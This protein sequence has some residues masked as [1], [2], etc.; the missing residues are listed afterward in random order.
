MRLKKYVESDTYEIPM[1]KRE[2]HKKINPKTNREKTFTH[3]RYLKTGISPKDRTLK[4]LPRYADGKPKV[5]FSDWML[6]DKDKI[7]GVSV[8]NIG[9]SKADG[10]WYGWSHRAISSFGI[11]DKIEGDNM[12]KK[13]EYPK[14]PNGEVDFDNGK[15]ESDFTVKT[16]GQAKRC[17]IN[18]ANSVR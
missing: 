4:N 16:D 14:L 18:F 1:L 10:R 5:H 12:G 15:Y 6:I 11:G 8:P 2:K 17:A 7:D 9:R 13:V 3:I